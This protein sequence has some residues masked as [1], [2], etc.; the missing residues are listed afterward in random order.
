M[1]HEKSKLEKA[2]VCKMDKWVHQGT[3]KRPCRFHEVRLLGKNRIKNLQ[4]SL[5]M[6]ACALISCNSTRF[7]SQQVKTTPEEVLARL[8]A[9]PSEG[10]P[11]LKA[12]ADGLIPTSRRRGGVRASHEFAVGPT[13]RLVVVVGDGAHARTN[14]AIEELVAARNRR[15][16]VVTRPVSTGFEDWPVSYCALLTDR[17]LVVCER[18]FANVQ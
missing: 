7:S 1:T 17:G 11:A 3:H 18:N 2:F 12:V 5:V 8:D 9:L 4:L 14:R 10:E 13:H 15:E 16:P 6:M